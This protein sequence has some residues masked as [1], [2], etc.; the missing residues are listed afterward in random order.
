MNKKLYLPIFF[1]VLSGC[2]ITNSSSVVSSLVSSIPI[3]TD[4]FN[5]TING[6][7]I[8]KE[9]I[10]ESSF[11]IV[12]PST[13]TPLPLSEF[14]FATT[15]DIV[16]AYAIEGALEGDFDNQFIEFAIGSP[17]IP[18]SLTSL[19]VDQIIEGQSAIEVL[20]GL[21]SS[22]ERFNQAQFNR[23]HRDLSHIYFDSPYYWFNQFVEEEEMILTRYENLVTFG[24]WQMFKMF[25]TEV[26]IPITVMYQLYADAKT[27]Y[28]IRD[29]TYPS[30]FFGAKDQ[31]FETIRTENNFKVALTMGPI[32]TLL[33][34]WQAFERNQTPITFPF[35]GDISL[36]NRSLS[37][38]KLS[39]GVYEFKLQV[40][41][42]G[43]FETAEE[44]YQM[45]FILRNSSWE[46]IEQHYQLW[47]P[48]TIHP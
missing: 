25:Q 18:L 20:E 46:N 21:R 8:L 9:T 7:T 14:N 43:S 40:Y 47:Q 23:K 33:Q 17:I 1:I 13:L 30:G 3:P 6:R 39:E 4:D 44:N 38:M 29:E 35:H 5:P 32:T 37:I 2:N 31:K 22:D 10:I 45:R 27:I 28:E 48:S 42:G 34:Q 12:Q 24:Q 41:L 36:A 15:E 26:V 11:D 19:N 16:T